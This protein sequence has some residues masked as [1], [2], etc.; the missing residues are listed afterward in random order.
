MTPVGCFPFG[1]PVRRLTQ[2]DRRPK[3]LFVLG[4]YASAVH[5]Q[6][7]DANGKQL[8]AALAVAS[9]P[10]IFWRGERANDVISQL[11]VPP[12]AGALKPAASRFNGPSGLA[13]DEQILSPLDRSREQAWLA[14]LVPHS[15]VNAQQLAAI[16]R[17][18]LPRAREL[19][20]P[21]PTTP[22]VPS[23]LADYARQDEIANELAESK[24]EVLVLL[25][26][27][28]IRWFSRRWYN[29]ASC[30]AD[31]GED[32]CSYGRLHEANIAGRHVQLLPLAHPRQIAR[33]G[34]HSPKWFALHAHWISRR[35]DP[36]GP[37]L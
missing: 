8:V 33:L 18:Y 30:L 10:Y 16:E 14:D 7:V 37:Q 25:G 17:E 20:L 32:E 11:Q 29:K 24:S 31:F 34:L 22:H 4:V 13:L 28:P 3:N 19:G 12:E 1:E 15:C 6:W 2:V 23:P 36:V 27:E 9:E 21:L 5:A 35:G 26:D